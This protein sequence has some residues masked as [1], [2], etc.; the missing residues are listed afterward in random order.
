MMRFIS[1]REKNFRKY[2]EKHFGLALPKDV[3]IFYAKGVRIGNKDI[4][5]SRITGELGYAA[6]DFGFNPTNSFIQNFGHLAGKNVVKLKEDEAR[7]FAAGKDLALDLGRKSKHVIMRY[8]DY[9]L[10]LGHYDKEKKKVL[11]KIPE[12]RRRNIVN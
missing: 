10:G 2:L 11:N 8:E 6:C 4:R 5:K 12:K 3:D 7:Q 9:T 1:S